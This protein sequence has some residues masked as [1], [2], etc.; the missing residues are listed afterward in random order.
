MIDDVDTRLRDGLGSVPLP[1][2]PTALRDYLAD[3]AEQ[4][5]QVHRHRR[6][7]LWIVLVPLAA[8]LVG[9]IALMG[10]SSP[11]PS[12]TSSPA[13][14]T[15]STSGTPTSPGYGFTRPGFTVT[16]RVA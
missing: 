3:L 11:N 5:P 4:P 10:G 2:A 6:A 9:I 7:R 15:A 13:A 14:S 1:V 8:V 16:H 12:P